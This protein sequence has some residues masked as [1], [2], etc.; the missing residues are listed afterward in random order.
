MY[1]LPNIYLNVF[2]EFTDFT[3]QISIYSIFTV[4]KQ[5]PYAFTIFR[6]FT[7][8]HAYCMD[9]PQDSEILFTFDPLSPVLCHFKNRIF[10]ICRELRTILKKIGSLQLLFTYEHSIYLLAYH[11]YCTY[12]FSQERSM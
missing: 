7:F 4:C 12:I 2:Y 1:I 11:I 10:R 6:Y 8:H 3:T 5:M 9:F